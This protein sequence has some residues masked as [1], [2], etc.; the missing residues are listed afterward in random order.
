MADLTIQDTATRLLREID[1]LFEPSRDL[2]ILLTRDEAAFVVEAPDG[3]ATQDL[4][5]YVGNVLR[6][7]LGKPELD[8]IL[9]SHPRLGE[10]HVESEA[11]QREQ[12]KLRDSATQLQ[13]LNQEYEA[14]F[15]G[16]RYVVF[17]AG[18]P[19]TSILQDMR[20]R[21]E[22]GDINRERERAICAMCDIARDRL[23][24]RG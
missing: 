3:H 15:P 11:S 20:A 4:I 23:K 5:T 21:I 18:R 13:Q 10:K 19:R 17:V 7:Q 16:L 24:Q 1:W 12:A 9:N 8:R 6:R 22:E 14:R 2:R